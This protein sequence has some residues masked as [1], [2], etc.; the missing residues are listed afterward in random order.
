MSKVLIIKTGSAPDHVEA[1]HGDFEDWFLDGLGIDRSDALIVDVQ[2]GESLPNSFAG[3]AGAVVTGSPA[4]V[5]HRAD[6]SERTARWLVDAHAAALPMLGV[7]YG[8]QLIAH[9]LGGVVG[10][11]PAGRR[12]GTKSVFIRSGD[13]CLLASMN[14]ISQLH[15]T[16]VEAVLKPPPSTRV[17]ADTHGDPHHALHFGQRSWG[18]QFHPEFTAGIMASYIHL[19]ADVLME[20]GQ[21]PDTL[22]A[23]LE[24]TPDGRRLLRDFADRLERDQSRPNPELAAS[25]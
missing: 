24:D 1:A 17:L 7:C 16:H 20:E 5:S 22:L 19:R 3:L 10:P 13:E 23:E 12:M 18:V 11:N 2:G 25:T 9:A 8:H 4:M 15:A 21:C 6:W 14:A